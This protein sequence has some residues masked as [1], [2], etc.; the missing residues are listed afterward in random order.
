MAT[1]QV[2]GMDDDLYRGLAARAASD[3]RSISQQVVTIVRQFLARPARPAREATEEFLALCGSWADERSAA[4][5]AGDIR[6]AR[7][8]DRRRR[9]GYRVL[10]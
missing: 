9:A 6:R 8:S 10:D 3:N 5:I 1:L 2:K 7:R 4:Q